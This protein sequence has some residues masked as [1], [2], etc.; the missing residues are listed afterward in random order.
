MVKR[1]IA[2]VFAGLALASSAMAEPLKIGYSDWPGWVTWEIAIEKNMFEEVGVDVEFEWFDYVASMDAFAAGQLDAVTMTNG[3]ALVTGATGAQ[4]VMILINDY[5][6]GND[7]I[8]AAP[9]IS[10]IKEL[11]GKKVGVEIGFVGHLLLLNALEK[12]GMTEKDVELVNVP[13]NETPQVLASGQVDA[14]VAWQPNSGQALT[15]VPGSTRIYSSKDE[16][17]LI[18]D[19]L[20]VTPSSLAQHQEEWAKVI[21]AW[22]MAVAYL[23][24][25]STRDEA[26]SI[27]AARVGL[28]PDEYKGFIDG[29][30]IMSTKE[31][32]AF[33]EKADGFTSIYGSSKIADDFNVAND[34][35]KDAQPIDSY[36]DMSLMKAAN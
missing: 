8:V 10:S 9:G 33:A 23:N 2:T 14:I 3:D 21:K 13:T 18:Y 22:D 24:D 4:N 5:S 16:P 36:I 34:V 31:A 32:M 19:V 6:N 29:T 15:L 7:M 30:K 20:A 28:S 1:L 11:K 35:Y 12:N 17:G 27:M 26:I 25:E